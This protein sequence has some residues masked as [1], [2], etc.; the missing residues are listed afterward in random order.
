MSCMASVQHVLFV[1]LKG[2]RVGMRNE[3]VADQM[4]V[5]LSGVLGL[6]I[7]GLCYRCSAAVLAHTYLLKLCIALHVV[8]SK[9]LII[10]QLLHA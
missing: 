7:K 9:R 10:L 1:L 6:T 8:I 2:M 5:Q 4:D 3:A